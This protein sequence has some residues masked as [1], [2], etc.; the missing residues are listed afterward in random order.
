M[1]FEKLLKAISIFLVPIFIT[2][3]ILKNILVIPALVSLLNLSLIIYFLKTKYLKHIIFKIYFG[4][5]F[6][7][8]IFALFFALVFYSSTEINNLL[9]YYEINEFYLTN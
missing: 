9:N 2:G 4:Y 1:K 6:L 7:T 8:L 3:I 5:Q